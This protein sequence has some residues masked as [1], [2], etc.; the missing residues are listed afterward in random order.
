[1]ENQIQNFQK[2]KSNFCERFINIF[3]GGGGCFLSGA[4]RRLT[5]AGGYRQWKVKIKVALQHVL[6]AHSGSGGIAWHF[7]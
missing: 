7:L 5:I 1:M 4:T 6:R 3:G 2:Q